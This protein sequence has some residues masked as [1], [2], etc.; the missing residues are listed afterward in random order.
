MSSTACG[1]IRHSCSTGSRTVHTS[2]CAA[3]PSGWPR[4]ST[5]LFTTSSP[6]AGGWTPLPRTPTSTTSSNPTDTCGTSTEGW[7]PW[8]VDRLS[9]IE[10]E[11]RRLAE[12]LAGAD[13]DNRCPTCPDWTAADLLWHLTEVH[14]FWA[15]V[16]SQDARTEADLAAV[17]QAKPER[18]T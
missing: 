14:L 7:H 1:R 11:S 18:P 13:P 17:E 9:I 10:S 15:G 3:T 16:L 4:T 8:T 5:P 6:A 12:V 2:T